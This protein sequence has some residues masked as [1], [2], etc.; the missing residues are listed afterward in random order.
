MRLGRAPLVL[1][2]QKR[3]IAEI[4]DR[5]GKR[6]LFLILGGVSQVT[7]VASSASARAM[8]MASYTVTFLP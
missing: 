2:R 4:E 1:R 8:Y 7:T 5:K 3:E 6:N